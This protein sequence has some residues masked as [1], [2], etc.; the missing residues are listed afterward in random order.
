MEK[1]QVASIGHDGTIYIF[2]PW[3]DGSMQ[4][5]AATGSGSAVRIILDRESI[6]RLVSLLSEAII[7]A[8][9]TG[10]LSQ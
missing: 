5:M 1:I 2:P 7:D 3:E 4:I 8:C 10:A 9:E 6:K